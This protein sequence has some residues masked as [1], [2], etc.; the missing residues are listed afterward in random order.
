MREPALSV[1][2]ADAAATEALG[3]ALAATRPAEPALLALAGDLGAGKTTLARGLLRALGVTGPIRSPTYTLVE[4]YGTPAGEVLHLDLYRLSGPAELRGLGFGDL[5]AG[6]ALVVVEWPERAREHLAV[7]LEV[8]LEL[9]G[10]GRR[11]T[12]APAS[13][14]GAAWAGRL[15]ERL[16]VAPGLRAGSA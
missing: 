4:P 10:E 2:L 7:D 8:L 12:L 16:G 15:G 3:A 9:A 14:A 11:A 13:G 5:A 6:A 1:A